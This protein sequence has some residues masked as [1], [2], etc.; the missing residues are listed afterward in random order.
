MNNDYYVKK[1]DEWFQEHYY[2]HGKPIFAFPD[3]FTSLDFKEPAYQAYLEGRKEAYKELKKPIKEFL[4]YME[5][6][7]KWDLEDI[8]LISIMVAVGDRLDKEPENPKL[9][10]MVD[11][12]M[13]IPPT[14]D[15]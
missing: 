3:K 1:F 11:A 4:D 7:P 12:I 15:D 9:R 13:K 6:K 8:T 2:Q 5:T 10:A 14:L